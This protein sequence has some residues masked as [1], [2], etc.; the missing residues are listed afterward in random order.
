MLFYMTVSLRSCKEDNTMSDLKEI[1]QKLSDLVS[2][3]EQ[4]S[5][6]RDRLEK[7]LYKVCDQWCKVVA[8]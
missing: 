5:R 3:K 7:E 4:A 6:H 8:A 2:Q 1:E